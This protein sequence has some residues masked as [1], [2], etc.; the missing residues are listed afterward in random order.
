MASVGLIVGEFLFASGVCGYLLWYYK[1]PYVTNDVSATGYIAWVFGL[2]GVMLLPYDL[3]MALTTPES[4]DS[5]KLNELWKF[6][7]WST[8][9]LAW[10][11]LTMQMEYH[12]SGHFSF[13]GK[14]L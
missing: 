5:E 12:H 8:F 1:S 14:V 6:I 13:K 11:I 10:V 7:Y 4:A 2:A 3:S 9:W